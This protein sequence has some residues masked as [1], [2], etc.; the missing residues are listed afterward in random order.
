MTEPKASRGKAAD[1]L[2]STNACG[3]KIRNRKAQGR[4]G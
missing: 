2:M 3:Q 4:V 1:E